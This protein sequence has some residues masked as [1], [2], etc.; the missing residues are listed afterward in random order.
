MPLIVNITRVFYIP[1]TAT[2]YNNIG[3][4]L[5]ERKQYKE[6]LIELRKAYT[7]YELVLG[8]KHSDAVDC[9]NWIKVVEQQMSW[10]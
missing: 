9:F 7:I 3:G 8:K 10:I 5:Y 6:A 1:D 2:C 4:V